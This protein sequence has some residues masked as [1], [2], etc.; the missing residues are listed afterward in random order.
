MTYVSE[1]IGFTIAPSI[2]WFGNWKN[3]V[4]A[5][6]ISDVHRKRYIYLKWPED[7]VMNYA[8]M[9]FRDYLVKYFSL[10]YSAKSTA[11]PL[12]L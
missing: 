11:L 3:R 9:K 10:T 6:P 12:N 4:I 7:T 2:T 5:I 8:T 1:G